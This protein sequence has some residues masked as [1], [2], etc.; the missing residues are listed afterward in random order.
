M[1][2]RATI[3]RFP[4]LVANSKICGRIV[5]NQCRGYTMKYFM[6]VTADHVVRGTI[7]VV[8]EMRVSQINFARIYV[9]LLYISPFSFL[10]KSARKTIQPSCE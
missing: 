1:K 9:L 4:Y 10:Q 7:V 5:F 8:V 3:D 6:L 2:L